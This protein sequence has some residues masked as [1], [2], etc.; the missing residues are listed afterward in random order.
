VGGQRIRLLG[1]G[2]ESI[3][4]GSTAAGRCGDSHNLHY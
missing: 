3:F 1:V 4:I 2:V